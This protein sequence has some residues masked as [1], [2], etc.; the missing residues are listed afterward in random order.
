[1]S[2]TAYYEVLEFVEF[3]GWVSSGRYETKREAQEEIR[4][5]IEAGVEKEDLRLVSNLSWSV[6]VNNRV[7]S[8]KRGDF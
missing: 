8:R 5:L 4:R 2:D 3:E 6:K 7:V 1:M